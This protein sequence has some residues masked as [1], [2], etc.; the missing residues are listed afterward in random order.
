[1]VVC[2]YSVLVSLFITPRMYFDAC[3]LV[4]LLCVGFFTQL[5]F[6]CI[7]LICGWAG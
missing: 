1:M 5:C 2:V 4:E 3:M 7:L 6:V